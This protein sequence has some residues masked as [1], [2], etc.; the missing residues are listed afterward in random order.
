MSLTWNASTPEPVPRPG[1]LQR[2]RMVARAVTLVALTYFGIIFVVA[3][4][5]VER[6]V[7]L[8][9]AH[10]ITRAWG[11]LCLWLCGL[12]V[13]RVGEPM[14]HP[15]AV[16]ANHTGWID[17]FTLLSADGVY[18]VS[19]AE[20]ARWP[21]VGWL[22]R[23][24][25]TVYIERKRS[26]AARQASQL[27]ERLTAGD[28]LCFF[29]EGTSTDGRQVV[30]FRSTLFAAFFEEGLRESVWVQPVTL[31]YAPRPPLPGSFYGWWGD[32]ALGPHL[33]AVFALSSRAEVTVVHHAPLKVSDYADRKA[34]A[35]AA[36][37][38]VRA[39]LPERG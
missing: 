31:V 25:G 28:R 32:M 9:I 27:H 13:R 12:R 10:R 6:V 19:K 37:A 34:L 5:L 14:R 3:F 35:A 22:S 15:G 16:V 38:A 7:P 18:F 2:L 8:G 24:I 30:P 33:A 11:K 36:E 4:N 1:V 39:G 26:S 29:P 20:V 21:V 23:Q 17:I